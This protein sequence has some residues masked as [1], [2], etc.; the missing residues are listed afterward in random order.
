MKTLEEIKET[1]KKQKPFLKDKYHIRDIGIF[2]SFVKGE[3]QEKSDL[4]LLVEFEKPVGFFKFLE[5]EEY[6]EMRD[7]SQFLMFWGERQP[8]LFRMG[9]GDVVE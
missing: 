1:L 7:A 6:L 2:G 5:L 4:D 9:G 3:Q 8:G